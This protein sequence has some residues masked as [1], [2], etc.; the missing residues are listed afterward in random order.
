M[1][2][3]VLGII[4]YSLTNP[5]RPFGSNHYVIDEPEEVTFHIFAS[6]WPRP[7]STARKQTMGTVR[8]MPICNVHC[9]LSRSDSATET[10]SW[11]V[12]MSD[13]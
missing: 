9:A 10:S 4:M 5:R 8:S 2:L 6:A 3:A 13:N 1:I 12:I 7:Y 11:G